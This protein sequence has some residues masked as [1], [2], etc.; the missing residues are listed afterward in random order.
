MVESTHRTSPIIV[1]S[2]FHVVFHYPYRTPLP[3]YNPKIT[4]ILPQQQSGGAFSLAAA[5]HQTSCEG[6]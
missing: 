5:K 2:S 3:K 6:R 1:V 4:L